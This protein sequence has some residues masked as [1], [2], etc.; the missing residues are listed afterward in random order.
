MDIQFFLLVTGVVLSAIHLLFGFPY[1][2]GVTLNT[3]VSRRLQWANA[4]SGCLMYGCWGYYGIRY[5]NW[6]V[7][8]AL[9]LGL[10][11]YLIVLLRLCFRR[12]M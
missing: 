11:K 3:S 1:M 2:I 12:I 10:L 5:V 8:F 4:I 7:G 9:G 6:L